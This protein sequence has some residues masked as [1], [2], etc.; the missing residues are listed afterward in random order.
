MILQYFSTDTTSEQS[1][2]WNWNGNAPIKQVYLKLQA[3]DQRAIIRD[4]KVLSLIKLEEQSIVIAI[5]LENRGKHLKIYHGLGFID[6]DCCCSYDM[7]I[8][9]FACIWLKDMLYY[10]VF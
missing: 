10:N 2:W 6:I 7:S 3:K 4:T 9:V 5:D 1:C 8:K